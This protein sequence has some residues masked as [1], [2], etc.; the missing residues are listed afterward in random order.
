MAMDHFRQTIADWVLSQLPEETDVQEVEENAGSI[1]ITLT[2]GSVK[3]LMIIDCEK[4]EVPDEQ[5]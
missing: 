1:W 3:S 2:D 4:E 5:T